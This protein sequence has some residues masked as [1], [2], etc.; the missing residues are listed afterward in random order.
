MFASIVATVVGLQLGS[1]SV[2]LETMVSGRSDL[3]FSTFL[4]FMQPIHLGIGV[5]E[6]LITAMIID[7]LYRH[8][9][10][11]IF[12]ETSSV[13]AKDRLGSLVLL[14]S[15][16]TL[17][18]GGFL[19]AYASSNPDGLEWSIDRTSGQQA[20]ASDSTLINTIDQ[21]QEH[22]AL[23]PDYQLNTDKLPENISKGLSGIIGSLIVLI[24]TFAIGF[25][26]RRRRRRLKQYE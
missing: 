2:V 24:L 23:L 5:V 20:L 1:F 10:D 11:L 18:I 6:G 9:S 3:P 13:N 17:V 26:L 16:A 7:Y 15:L 19:S 12:N 14:L 4:L 22:V 25:F 21:V 8:N